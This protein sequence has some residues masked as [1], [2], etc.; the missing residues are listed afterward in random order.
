MKKQVVH[1]RIHG[2]IAV[3]GNSCLH[4]SRVAASSM[5]KVLAIRKRVRRM[6]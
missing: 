3:S 2:K 4:D 1:E 6:Q 5:G